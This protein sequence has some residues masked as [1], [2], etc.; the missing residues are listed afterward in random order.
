MK[1]HEKWKDII[2]EGIHALKDLA[3]R[4]RSLDACVCLEHLFN[5][6]RLVSDRITD[7]KVTVHDNCRITF[8]NQISRK[9]S[10]K[11][12]L[13]TIIDEKVIEESFN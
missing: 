10:Q 12:N 4:W 8:R 1:N 7:G 9:E 3:K 2:E 6:F 11:K 13:P 5:E